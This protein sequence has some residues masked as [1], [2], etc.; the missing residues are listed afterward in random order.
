MFAW[1]DA[2]A[3]QSG[4]ALVSG[5]E[6]CVRAAWPQLDAAERAALVQ[7]VGR[8]VEAAPAETRARL[9]LPYF[10]LAEA[11]DAPDV[12]LGELRTTLLNSTSLGTADLV[13]LLSALEPEERTAALRQAVAARQ[14]AAVRAFVLELG[15]ALTIPLDDAQGA[16]LAESFAAAPRPKAEPEQ[17]YSLIARAGWSNCR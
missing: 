13:G 3:K 2:V 10:R 12:P 8:I 7:R 15:A 1:L 6:T 16:L 4:P 9:N 14:P 5:L 11:L 17:A